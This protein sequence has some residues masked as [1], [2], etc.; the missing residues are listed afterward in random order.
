M[1]CCRAVGGESGTDSE[2]DTV[3]SSLVFVNLDLD[4]DRECEG[5]PSMERGAERV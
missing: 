1:L 3:V 5:K 4:L 2:L